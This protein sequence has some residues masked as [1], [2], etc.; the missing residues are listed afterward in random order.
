MV[1]CAD[2]DWENEGCNGG[3]PA[4]AFLYTDKNPLMLQSDYEYAAVDQTCQY[5]SK[6]KVSGASSQTFSFVPN[7]NPY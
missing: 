4:F 5:D 7:N 2:G 6:K 3:L 1:D